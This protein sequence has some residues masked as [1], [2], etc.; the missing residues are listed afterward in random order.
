[1]SPTLFVMHTNDSQECL[2]D[3]MAGLVATFLLCE[4]ANPGVLTAYCCI[5]H[6][7]V[8]P[9]RLWWVPL[10]GVP[11]TAAAVQ[12]LQAAGLTFAGTSLQVFNNF[13][14]FR[15]GVAA[16]GSLA[17]PTGP[18]HTVVARGALA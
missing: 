7:Y 17:G 8:T 14:Y 15:C 16:V 12:V 13:S 6:I 10:A 11:S 4:A 1:M 5:R 3:A 2:A 9:L 18:V